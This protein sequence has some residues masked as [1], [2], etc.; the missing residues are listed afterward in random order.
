ML[1][2][3]P[4]P[5]LLLSGAL[6]LAG[7]ASDTVFVNHEISQLIEKG[8]DTV[9]K[10]G[11]VEICHSGSAPWP[12]IEALAAE[13]CATQGWQAEFYMTQKWQ[14][15]MTAPHLSTFRCFLPEY[16]DKYGRHLNPADRKAYR[17]WAKARGTKAAAH[18]AA[19]GTGPAETTVPAQGV[20]ES[21]SV[22]SPVLIPAARPLRPEDIAGK[23]PASAQPLALPPVPAPQAYPSGDFTLTPGSWGD[24]FRE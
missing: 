13:E 7:C 16:A 4:M 14:C 11:V 12:E 3:L 9:L 5:V 15:R 21:T 8:Q 18:P 24:Q 10:S 19:A 17:A 2:R 6:V 23:P 1:R 22:P 20:A